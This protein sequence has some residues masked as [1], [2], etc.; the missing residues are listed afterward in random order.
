V[1]IGA[2]GAYGLLFCATKWSHVS[3]VLLCR[4]PGNCFPQLGLQN[5]A[6]TGETITSRSR[7]SPI[8]TGWWSAQR[9]DFRSPLEELANITSILKGNT[10]R[11]ITV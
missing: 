7:S 1:R 3:A 11:G 6:I 2:N 10:K 9:N 5:F 4:S 8:L